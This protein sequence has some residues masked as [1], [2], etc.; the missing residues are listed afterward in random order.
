M[1]RAMLFTVLGFIV[2][3]GMV[4]NNINKTSESSSENSSEYADAILARNVAN[5]A[6][7]YGLSLYIS[8]GNDSSYTNSDFLGGSYTATFTTLGDTV[9]LI[10]TATYEDES[11]T[12]RVDILSEYEH[13]PNATGGVLVGGG[14]GMMVFD[15]GGTVTIT[16]NDTN[17]DGSDGPGPDLAAFTLS[18]DT[19][20]ASLAADSSFLTGD[21]PIQV[22]EDTSAVTVSELV[23]YYA[24]I[25]D[26]TIA[27]GSYNN[28]T[29]G[30]EANPVILYSSSRL[31][32]GT[33]TIGYGILAVEG[34]LAMGA[35]AVWYGSVFIS[36]SDSLDAFSANGG[37]EIY[38]TF[39]IGSSDT[40]TS[41]RMVGNASIYYS[42][43]GVSVATA[44]FVAAVNA[45]AAA[46]TTGT[47]SS[48][49]LTIQETIWYE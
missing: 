28:T 2:I 40:T 38:G 1:G 8:T 36:A 25:A 35:S 3:F 33:N 7:E 49:E 37:P 48:A 5:S 9:R 42:T 23:A 4:R 31:V 45:A 27:G 47:T 16:G 29:W 34:S 19:D 20:S 11:H 6:L 15:L 39:S 24:T 46:D 13:F 14:S 43:Q 30:S 17:F 32:M 26:I 12:S 10:V 22:I 44:A 21:P 41:L 18:S